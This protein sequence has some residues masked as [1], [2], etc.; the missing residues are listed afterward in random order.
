MSDVK[1]V[2]YEYMYQ[3]REPTGSLY[4]SSTGGCMRKEIFRLQDHEQTHPH[5]EK[6][7]WDFKRFGW[8]E[9]PINDAMKKRY[10]DDI[11]F[12]VE[13]TKGKW[14]GYIDMVMDGTHIMEIKSISPYAKVGNLPYDHHIPQV[15]TYVVMLGE[16]MLDVVHDPITAEIIYIDRW[17]DKVPNIRSYD[18]TP[19]DAEV[20]VHIELMEEFEQ[21]AERDDYR[22]P[23]KPREQPEDHPWECMAQVYNRKTRIKEP[24]IR[25]PYFG[26]CWHDR[27]NKDGTLRTVEDP[28]P[29]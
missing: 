16:Q 3:R 1:D 24:Q 19:T 4:P 7:L 5:S 28:F 27:V 9:Q 2:V 18:V 10:G 8:Y 21:W 12:Q 11:Q 25:C 26:L 22:V 6:T 14:H 29:F 17:T 13:V 15:L 20:F 23:D